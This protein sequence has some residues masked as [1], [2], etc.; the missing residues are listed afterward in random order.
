MLKALL[1]RVFKSMVKAPFLRVLRAQLFE[2][3]CTLSNSLGVRFYIGSILCT[4]LHR[5]V[6]GYV[7]G[8]TLYRGLCPAA[9]NDPNIFPAGDFSGYLHGIKIAKSNF[10][11]LKCVCKIQTRNNMDKM[12]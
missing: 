10:S 4:E 7:V 8:L 9:C 1:L 12:Y 6:F 5:A 2:K 11:F 3:W